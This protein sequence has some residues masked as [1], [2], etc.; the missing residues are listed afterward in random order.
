LFKKVPYF[1]LPSVAGIPRFVRD[2][3]PMGKR[4]PL[5]SLRTVTKKKLGATEKGLE[6]T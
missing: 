1:V 5:A 4:D 3:V 2:G 6:E